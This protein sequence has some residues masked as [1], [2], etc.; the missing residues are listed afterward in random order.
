[1]VWSKIS[2]SRPRV[3]DDDSHFSIGDALNACEQALGPLDVE[4]TAEAGEQA[5]LFERTSRALPRTVLGGRA[6]P[7]AQ[8]EPAANTTLIDWSQPVRLPRRAQEG[9]APLENIDYSGFMSRSIYRLAQ[10]CDMAIAVTTRFVLSIAPFLLLPF[11]FWSLVG[12]YMVHR[13]VASCAHVVA[14]K[15]QK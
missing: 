1:M 6:P 5:P 13:Y 2:W 10:T 15:I 12:L 8:E 14:W 4:A 3:Q 7:S 9:R 11:G